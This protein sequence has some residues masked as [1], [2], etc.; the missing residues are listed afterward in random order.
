AGPVTINCP[1]PLLA[2]EIRASAKAQNNGIAV[3][4][5]IN[6]ENGMK[7][8][9][10]ERSVDMLN[11]TPITHFAAKNTGQIYTYVD[12]IPFEGR[13]YYRIKGISQSGEV[14][15]SNIASEEWSG[16]GG[17]NI[18]P[19]PTDLGVYVAFSKLF[20]QREHIKVRLLNTMGIFVMEKDYYLEGTQKTI[21]IP[22]ENLANGI[23]LLEIGIG[24][25]RYV[26]KLVVKH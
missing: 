7:E 4:W 11:F 5:Y 6:Q 22:T 12:V 9:I 24:D 17:I 3:R 2:T 8:Y 26:S 10:I 23:Y 16:K 19:N 21:F 1:N 25:F 18:Y 14:K 20:E 15:Y 13:N